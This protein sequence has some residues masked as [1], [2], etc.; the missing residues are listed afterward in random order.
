MPACYIHKELG[1]CSK[2]C[3]YCVDEEIGV[4]MEEMR[5]REP[6]LDKEEERRMAAKNNIRCINICMLMFN[7]KR[8]Y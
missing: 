5:A 3:P 6:V 4:W 7:I 2:H 1:E 8:Y